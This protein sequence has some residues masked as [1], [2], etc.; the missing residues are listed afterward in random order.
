[1]SDSTPIRPTKSIVL[2]ALSDILRPVLTDL[3]MLDLFAGT[4]RVSQALLKEGISHSYAVDLNSSPAGLPDEI[5]W[6]ESSVEKFLAGPGPREQID[7]VY[8]DPPYNY[9]GYKDLVASAGSSDWFKKQ[10][11]VVVETAT[12]SPPLPVQITTE[13][14]Q[15]KRSLVLL[16]EREY[17]ATRLS[18]YQADRPSPAVE[19]P[20]KSGD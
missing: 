14:G 3:V 17:G 10:G 5:C 7:L 20:R 19:R 12:V 18:V 15:D 8:M 9:S 13:D 6:I 16:R 4:G 11:I 1:M 2:K